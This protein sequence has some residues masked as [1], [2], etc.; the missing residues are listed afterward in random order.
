MSTSLLK[1]GVIGLDT[2]HVEGFAS[3]LHDT[4]NPD[5]VPGGRIVAGFPGG[6]PDFPLSA[7]RVAGYTQKLRDEHGVT[8]F[9]SPREVA[10]AVD[11]ILHTT[12]DGRIH[13][14][15]FAEIATFHKPVFLDKPF[16]VTSQDARAIAAMARENK[17]PLFSSSSL[18]FAGALQ[19]ALGD[20]RGG[21]II[22]ADFFG[23]LK[24]QPTQ[25]GF[26]WYGI[27]TAEMLYA[28]LGAG[29][30]R[31]RVTATEHHEVAVGTWRDGRIGIIRGN[32]AGNDSFGGIIH[33]E[34]A[35]QWVD[36]AAGRRP[37]AGLTL[38]IMDFFRGGSPPVALDETVEIIRFLEAANESRDH[39]GRE[40]EL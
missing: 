29:C 38:A 1:I 19:T 28:A 36:V 15:Q 17:T 35:S 27:H 34:K 2:S 40:V 22:G 25:P 33:R 26:F 16:A 11:A 37:D 20:V 12:V 31:V 30:V 39:A 18:R 4:S 7:T 13:R 6:S 9:G 24:L 14:E 8:M 10:A 5:H 32:R 23:P 3:L 21:K